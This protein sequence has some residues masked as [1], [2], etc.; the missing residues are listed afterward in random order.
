MVERNV[1]D[2]FGTNFFQNMGF[3]Q[4]NTE[5]NKKFPHRA[6]VSIN[7]ENRFLAHIP[8]FFS[9]KSSTVV[10]NLVWAPTVMQK[11]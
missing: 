2:I 11:H 5:N 9:S 1:A 10:Q 7:S 4:S 8:N 3:V 6:N